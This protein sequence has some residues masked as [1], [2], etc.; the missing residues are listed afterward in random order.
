FE[1]RRTTEGSGARIPGV[2]LHDTRGKQGNRFDTAPDRKLLQLLGGERGTGVSRGN[3]DHRHP[4][5]RH[6]DAV[7][8][9]RSPARG[10]SSGTERNLTPPT[11]GDF[12]VRLGCQNLAITLDTDLV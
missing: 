1:R 4:P 3:V 5:A 2:R 12:D 10:S 9:D 7:H 11:D 6:L 8:I